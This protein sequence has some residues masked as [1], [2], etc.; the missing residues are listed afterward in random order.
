[1]GAEIRLVL[2]P[3]PPVECLSTFTPGIED[4]ST[5]EPEFIMA[6]VIALT[7]RSVMPEKIHGHRKSR[8]LVIGDFAASVAI[9]KVSKFLW[10]KLLSIPLAMNQVDSTHF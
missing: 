9:H 3:T 4:R 8:H 5:I 1:M 6:S 7:S 2:S 10:G